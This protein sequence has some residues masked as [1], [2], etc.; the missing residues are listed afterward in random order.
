MRR[1]GLLGCE[2]LAEIPGRLKR[3]RAQLSPRR[4]QHL[5]VVRAI[6]SR[7]LRA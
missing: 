4:R 6:G 5:I 3:L 1:Y 2:C 7:E